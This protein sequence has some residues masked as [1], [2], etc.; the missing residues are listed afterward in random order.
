MMIVEIQ[1]KSKNTKKTHTACMMTKY[2]TNQEEK[3][4]SE[5]EVAPHYALLTLFILFKMLYLRCLNRSKYADTIYIYI[6]RQG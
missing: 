2:S 6:A 1:K 3:I 5:S 4:P